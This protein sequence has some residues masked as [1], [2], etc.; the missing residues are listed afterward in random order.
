[1]NRYVALLMFVLS[2]PLLAQQPV[3]AA[4]KAPPAPKAPQVPPAP[5][6]P[7]APP[8]F[9]PEAGGQ[10]V[11]IRLDVSVTDQMVNSPAQP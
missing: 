5:A 7:P 11:N 8:L 2:I 6:V 1:M 4:P 10:P 3:P 9:N